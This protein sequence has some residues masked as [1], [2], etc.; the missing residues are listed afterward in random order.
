LVT[1]YFT[2]GRLNN[3]N[4]VLLHLRYNINS[5]YQTTAAAFSS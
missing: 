3:G 4:Y 1:I 5:I 2:L